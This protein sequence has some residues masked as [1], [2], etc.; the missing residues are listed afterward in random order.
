[1]TTPTDDNRDLLTVIASMKA[2]PGKEDQ[3]RAALE[4]LIEPTRQE[5][6]YVNYDLHESV[7]DPGRFFFYENWHSGEHLDAHLA[8][9]HL[10]A[11]AERI[12]DLLDGD[13]L[14]VNRV[15]RIA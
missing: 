12:P 3:L 9:P 10:V 14:T 8:A 7:E 1:M 11:F 13:G 2:A 4:Q 5:D 6:G 15:R